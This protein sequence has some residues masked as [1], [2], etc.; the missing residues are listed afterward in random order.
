MRPGKR[1]RPWTHPHSPGQRSSACAWC[2]LQPKDKPCHGDWTQ[3]TSFPEC[4]DLP[5]AAAL[6]LARHRQGT[7]LC[8]TPL[9][10]W[11]LGSQTH[12]AGARPG[13]QR[14]GCWWQHTTPRSTAWLLAIVVEVLP[15]TT[16][17]KM[18]VLPAFC[19]CRWELFSI[20]AVLWLSFS[21]K[22]GF[23]VLKIVFFCLRSSTWFFL[24]VCFPCAALLIH[25]C[26]S[27]LAATLF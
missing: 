22:L 12:F 1:A 3:S 5:P 26:S 7:R 13:R 15:A 27:V 16:G 23:Y 14:V 9:P 21:W 24:Q 17:P 18:L 2:K 19:M 11:Q 10:P 8:L 4:R 20:L 6:L 25:V